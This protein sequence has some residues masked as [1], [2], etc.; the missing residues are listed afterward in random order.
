MFPYRVVF[1]LRLYTV[2]EML[3]KNV[4]VYFLYYNRRWLLYKTFQD[5]VPFHCKTIADVTY[6]YCSI[7][8]SSV[9]LLS[10]V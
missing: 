8:L 2:N 6:V 7:M 9:V 4:V 10:S 1:A 5:I 3:L